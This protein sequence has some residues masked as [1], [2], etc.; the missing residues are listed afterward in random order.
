MGS[1]GKRRI[2]KE[3]TGSS[4]GKIYFSIYFLNEK[5]YNNNI[6]GKEIQITWEKLLKKI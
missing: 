3:G 6:I 2:Q 1:G 4:Q 5:E